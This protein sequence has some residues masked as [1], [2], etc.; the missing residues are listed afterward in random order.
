MSRVFYEYNK[1]A[2][3]VFNYCVLGTNIKSSSMSINKKICL[4]NQLLCYQVY[5]ET[6]DH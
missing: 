2:I 5:E 4:N 1:L 6:Y 3:V